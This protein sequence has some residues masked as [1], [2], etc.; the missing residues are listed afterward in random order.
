MAGSSAVLDGSKWRLEALV[1][2]G[3][4]VP[5][6]ADTEVALEFAG[7]TVGGSAGCNRYNASYTA[8]G[9]HLSVTA[10]RQT[11][12]ICPNP[13]G[14][15]EQERHF[16]AAL[17]AATTYRLADDRLEL[18]GADGSPSCVFTRAGQATTSQPM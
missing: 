10:P 8:D 3:N 15:M 9:D 12:M 7:K 18:L 11:R 1:E 4:R 2:G 13:A 16:L 6:L 14:V 17:Q 5:V